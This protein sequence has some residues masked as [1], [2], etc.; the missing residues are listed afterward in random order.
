MAER[1]S[2]LKLIEDWVSYKVF[3]AVLGYA[4]RK[5]FEDRI[6]WFGRFSARFLGPI[7]GYKRRILKNLELIYPDMSEPEKQAFADRMLDNFGRTLGENFFG[8]DFGAYLRSR[9][10]KIEGEGLAALQKAK[11]EGRP[12]LMVAGHFG[13]HEAPRHLLT[14]MGFTIGGIYRPMSN[15][16]FDAHY[17]NTLEILGGEV[18]RQGREGTFAFH[19]YLLKGGIGI[20]FIDVHDP[21]GEKLPFL[22]RPCDTPVSAARLAKR[23]NAVVIPFFGI[24][25]PDGHGFRCVLEAP[26]DIDDPIPMTQEITARLEARVHD[27]PDQ[28]FWVHRRWKS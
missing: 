7:A 11:A 26:V 12:V 2:R 17:E 14:E 28:W 13:N 8:R 6:A 25:L 9:G 5:P 3:Q 1:R 24:R 4:G 22:G 18:F 20:L 10:T 27:N 19:R 21:E 16:Y 15:R 23:C